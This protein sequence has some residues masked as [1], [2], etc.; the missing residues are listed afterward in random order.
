MT[1]E[2]L[3]FTIRKYLGSIYGIY[4][5]NTNHVYINTLLLSQK[6]TF[7][8]GHTY[9]MIIKQNTEILYVLSSF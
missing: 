6:L 4:T 2:I 1:V 8:F 9:P 7:L 5:I 3:P